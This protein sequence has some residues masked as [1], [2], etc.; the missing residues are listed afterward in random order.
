M[1]FEQRVEANRSLANYLP[2]THPPHNSSMTTFTRNTTKHLVVPEI[3][4]CQLSKNKEQPVEDPP[5]H[6][7]LVGV[8]P[9]T[10]PP[11]SPSSLEEFSNS[12]TSLE[13]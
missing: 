13:S 11:S 4:T 7:H 9:P 12:D 5:L 3:K 6:N 1:N 8:P 10:P 2:L